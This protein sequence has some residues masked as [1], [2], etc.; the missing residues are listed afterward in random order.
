MSKFQQEL[1]SFNQII[2]KIDNLL[3]N[4]E[5]ILGEFY[6]DDNKVYSIDKI[7]VHQETL[8]KTLN[9]T[10]V[11]NQNKDLESPYSKAV[12][13]YLETRYEDFPDRKKAKEKTKLLKDFEF[14]INEIE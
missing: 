2:R 13:N 14:Y 10:M 5:K 12:Y 6:F 4:G 3:L 11:F 9:Y 7:A 8:K 1:N